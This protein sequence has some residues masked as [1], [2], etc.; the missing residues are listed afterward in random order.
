MRRAEDDGRAHRRDSA[1]VTWSKRPTRPAPLRRGRRRAVTAFSLAAAATLALQGLAYA[2]P[3]AAQEE[4]FAVTWIAAAGVAVATA[5][6]CVRLTAAPL[7]RSWLI[8]AGAVGTWLTGAALQLAAALTD[9]HG[10]EL[11]ADLAWLVL[12]VVAGLSIAF[13]APR[14]SL[15]FGLFLLDAI[16]IVLLV[17]VLVRF[18][19]PHPLEQMHAHE[20]LHLGFP[21]LYVLVALVG[22]QL[23][24]LE[25]DRL[26]SPNL[27][28]FGVAQPLLAVGAIGWPLVSQG[29]AAHWFPWEAFWT[30]GM[31]TAG[32]AAVHRASKPFDVPELRPLD[33]NGLRALPTALGVLG[34]LVVTAVAP[35]DYREVPAALAVL[36]LA[37][38]TA[39]AI[40]VQR[41]HRLAHAT[42]EE[43]A[44]K[45]RTLV[46]NIPGVVYRCRLDAA[47]TIEFMSD[48][49][50]SLTGYPAGDFVHN[51]LQSFGSIEHP[52]DTEALNRHIRGRVEAGRPYAYEYRIVRADGEIRWVLDRGQA[53]WGRDGP[54]WV[55]GVLLDVSERKAAEERLER[56]TEL[57][58]L[59]QRVAVAAN[60]AR[61]PEEA[62]QVA[63]DEVCAS[64]GWPLGHVLTR[65]EGTDE[66][67]STGIWHADDP[68]ATAAF[69]EVTEALVFTPGVGLPGRVLA[70]RHAEWVEDF[71]V[72]THWPR[73]PHALA[74]DYRAAF[75]FPVLVGTEVVGV[76]EFFAPDSA[77]RD[78]NLLRIMAHIG[79]VLGRVVER[80]RAE[81]ALAEQNEALRQLDGLKDEFVSLVSHEL[82]TPLTSIRGYLELVLDDAETPL[83]G[84]HRAFLDVVQR[85]ADRLLRLVGDLLFV[86][87]VDAGR[88]IVERAE[89]DL[90]AVAAECVKAAEPIAARREVR[91]V[92]DARPTVLVGD[93]AR[94]GQLLDNL[95]SN[96]IKFSPE[97]GEV[98][99]RVAA[100]GGRAELDVSDSGIGI[101]ADEQDQLF[102]RFFRSSNARRAAI[103]GTGLGLVIFRA[104]AEA[105]GGTVAVTSREG[106]GT[107]FRVE[108]PLAAPTP[109]IS[110]D[111][112]APAERALQEAV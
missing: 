1:T 83:S 46:S 22:I 76:L 5:L 52:E 8:W 56:Q 85:N 106:E 21:L 99:V 53:A 11:A 75:A 37:C 42:L 102:E 48:E 6:V 92:V 89:V 7:R 10:F 103:Q 96:A 62:F 69:Q 55:D 19:T 49:I 18:A 105:H 16:P 90:A 41:E 15:S 78:E 24:M 27:W 31:L 45:L 28:G 82:R 2:A 44:E 94:L 80:T 47:W 74:L 35:A 107:T 104:I 54:L 112:S 108:L 84:E 71:G 100:A 12:P 32:G 109:D 26:R 14:G 17:T 4:L 38:L 63:A 73:H 86:A 9:A 58:W 97:G 57:L 101:P 66:L 50:E 13:D 98:R 65:P 70:S 30:L 91:V 36:S 33:E 93:R 81:H 51:R 20:L 79:T 77:G 72:E 64:T 23:L 88:L 3:S 59:L 67:V 60:E 34:L 39:R 87:Q 111:E 25:R 95:V 40:V 43:N 68:D 110:A 61:E 29:A